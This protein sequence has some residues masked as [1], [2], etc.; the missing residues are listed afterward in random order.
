[1]AS[2]GATL[3]E[4]SDRRYAA[5]DGL[6]GLAALI[7][8]AS[9]AS[10]S[11]LHLVPGVSLAG[12]GKYGVYLF[13][14]LSAF[15]LSVQWLQ[16]WSA[17]A[18]TRTY[19]L[20][21]LA[22]RVLRIYP[23]YVVVLLVGLALA[24]RGLGVPLDGAA[25]WRHL[26]LQE[27]RGHYWSIPVEFLYYL[28]I[29]VL[30]FV[31]SR[32][33]PVALRWSGLVAVVAAAQWFWPPDEITPNSSNLLFYLPVFIAGTAAAW[34]MQDRA[35]KISQARVSMLDVLLL[36]TLV[37]AIP[38]VHVGLGW[39]DDA[40]VLTTQFVGWG[41]FWALVLLGLLGGQLPAWSRLL[42]RPFWR[43]CGD[44]C[45][46]IYLLHLPAVFLLRHLPFPSVVNAWLA[47]M[48][49]IMLGALSYRYIEK[50]AM[51][52]GAARLRPVQA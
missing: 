41:I 21:Y 17:G 25:V 28:C 37:A 52:A 32:R 19:L 44:W 30:S 4:S 8:V 23:L 29:P 51:Q 40:G 42:S 24:P 13:F 31:L 38:A 6:R 33:L 26:T 15:L 9:H 50:P 27:G 34:F 20:G 43:A 1:M 48:A 10:L 49:A 45:F 14:V 7:V 47:L 12:V 35:T 22:R 18:V 2:V 39:T 16:A 46:G 36:L 11:G 5:L 3:V